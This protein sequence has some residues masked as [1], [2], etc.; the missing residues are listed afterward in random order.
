MSPNRTPS[1]VSAASQAAPSTRRAL[2]GATQHSG[3]HRAGRAAPGA[4]QRPGAAAGREPRPVAAARRS[5]RRTS[6][7]SAALLLGQRLR[8]GVYIGTLLDGHAVLASIAAF[9]DLLR[10]LGRRLPAQRR[11][12]P[13]GR[14]AASDQAVSA[15]RL[16]RGARVGRAGDR[17]RPRRSVALGAA[18]WLRP[19]FGAAGRRLCRRCSRCIP[20]R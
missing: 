8:D 15:D 11:R 17:R 16:G 19:A 7:S 6:S 2:D 4:R 12:R 10:A 13:G 18:F 20:A 5:G 14:R 9:V 3:H 1:R